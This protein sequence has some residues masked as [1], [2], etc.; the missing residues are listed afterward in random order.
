MGELIWE[1]VRGILMGIYYG[2]LVWGRLYGKFIWG[3]YMGSSSLHLHAEVYVN[4]A[5]S[6]T[7]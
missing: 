1:A 4:K 2:E 7:M 5:R 6:E 3:V